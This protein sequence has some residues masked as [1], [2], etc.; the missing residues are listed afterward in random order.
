MTEAY[1]RK[2]VPAYIENWPAEVQ[3][4]SFRQAGVALTPE[5]TRSLG[6]ACVGYDGWFA[7]GTA[8]SLDSLAGQLENAFH[9]FP[10]GAMVRLG[11]RS[12]KDSSFARHY[13]LRVTTPA[14]AL[15]MLTSGSRRV[16]QDFRLAIRHSYAP[17]VFLREWQTIPAWAEFR[18]FVRAGALIG[19]SQYDA[20]TLGYCAEI[21]SQAESIEVAI[22]A[23]CVKLRSVSHLEELAADVFVSELSNATG[24][25]VTLIEVNPLFLKTG[26]C[27]FDWCRNDFDGSF[28]FV[29]CR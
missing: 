15:A 14:E 27:L 16:A 1:F 5:Q 18:C 24:P 28:R 3:A 20:T 11:S 7:E 22:R 13:G 26:S 2:V 25:K 10:Q 8:E 29:S 19:I 21:A 6:R 17:H 23:F 9:S 12:A 4:L